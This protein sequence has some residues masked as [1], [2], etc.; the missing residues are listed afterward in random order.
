MRR[1]GEAGLGGKMRS[2]VLDMSR[3]C[4]E[5]PVK[6]LDTVSLGLLGCI[7]GIHQHGDGCDH[8][9]K[10]WMERRRGLSTEPQER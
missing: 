5:M 7:F 8:Q 10:V 6:Q 4:L 9:V 2:L 3:G 1:T